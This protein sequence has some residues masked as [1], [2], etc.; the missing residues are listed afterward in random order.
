[1]LISRSTRRSETARAP[2]ALTTAI[3]AAMLAT[4]SISA[5]TGVAHAQSEEELL[6]RIERQLAVTRGLQLGATASTGSTAGTAETVARE[7]EASTESTTTATTTV[8][9]SGTSG[10]AVAVSAGGNSPLL[11]GCNPADATPDEGYLRLPDESVINLRINFE[12]NSA[13][14]TSTET[15]KVESLCRAIQ[16]SD[17]R[18]FQVIGHADATGSARYNCTLS[19]L[20]A[21]EVRRFMVEQCGIE[22]TRL[23]AVGLGEEQPADRANPEAASNRRVELQ[24]LM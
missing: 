14:L 12:H 7:S 10:A 20:R 11:A 23:R 17:G 15:P 4:L 6:G 3:A 24:A 8:P 18:L 9:S 2:S 19:R 5:W 16:R 21:E 13:V 1:M 22:A